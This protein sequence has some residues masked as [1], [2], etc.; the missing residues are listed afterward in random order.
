MACHVLRADRRVLSDEANV[1]FLKSVNA[2]AVSKKM[3]S[4]KV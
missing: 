1:P 2:G 3:T 4:K